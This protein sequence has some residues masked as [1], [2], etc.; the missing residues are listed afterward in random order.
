MGGRLTVKHKIRRRRK[1]T[2]FI[3]RRLGMLAE[4]FQGSRPHTGIVNKQGKGPGVPKI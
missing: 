3:W 1:S 2:K 4:K